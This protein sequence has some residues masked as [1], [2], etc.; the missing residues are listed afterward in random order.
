MTPDTDPDANPE[1]IIIG[2][3][4]DG[5]SNPS[6]TKMGDFLGDITGVVYY[7]FGFYRILPLTAVAPQVSA[8]A[9]F[10]PV[11]FNSTGNCRG[12]T[13]GV[14]NAENLMPDSEHMPDIVNQVV[15]KLYTPDLIFLQEVQDNSGS[16]N[17]GVTSA[18]ITLAT[19][20]QGIEEAS[21]VQYDF[22]EVEPVDGQDGGQ[23]GGNIR[24]AYLY[25]P[26]TLQLY[27]PNQGGSLDENEVLDGPELK[28]N[29]GRI[30]PANSAFDNSRKPLAAMWKPVKGTGKAFFTVNV[31]MG[32]KGGSSTL[33]G[34]ARPPVNKGVEK[35][36]RQNEATAVSFHFILYLNIETS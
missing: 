16:T 27:K 2:N 7:A 12:I 33:H 23:P 29:P 9:D 31:H 10:P 3:P 30:D 25:R 5:S 14:Y 11:S 8:S 4:L 17:D 18:N 13:F 24:C 21:G 1:A 19:L 20:A 26:D 32:S 6:D 35:R 36:T 34:D 22:T 28:F 15:H